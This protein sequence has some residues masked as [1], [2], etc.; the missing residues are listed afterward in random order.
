MRTMSKSVKKRR[1]ILLGVIGILI[2]VLVGGVWGFLHQPSFGQLPSGERL[3]RIKKSPHYK[4]G[5]FQNL[6]DTPLMTGNDNR[7]EAMWNFVFGSRD[8]LYPDQPIPVVK[9]DL[10]HLPADKNL[11][12]WFGHSSYCFRLMGSASW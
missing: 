1:M 11:M 5:A 4:N 7:W 9:T 12:V 3:E 8:N 6:H 10:K 2:I